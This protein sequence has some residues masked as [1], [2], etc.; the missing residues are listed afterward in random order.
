VTALHVSTEEADKKSLKKLWKEKVELPAKAAGSAVPSLEMVDSPYRRLYQPILDFVD[1]VKKEK[2]DRL[3][4]V[5]IPELVEPHWYEYLL[6]TLHSARLRALLY[7][8]RD[9]RTVVINA[10]WYLHDQ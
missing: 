9:Q 4:A 5:V 8:E 2:P 10:P 7:H 1:K 3:I 6:H